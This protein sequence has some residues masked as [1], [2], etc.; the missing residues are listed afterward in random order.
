MIFQ[1]LFGRCYEKETSLL[2]LMEAASLLGL[3]FSRTSA[4]YSVQQDEA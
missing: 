2:A 4:R 3:F 1:S